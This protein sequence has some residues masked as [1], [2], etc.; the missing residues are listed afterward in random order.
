MGFQAAVA[1]WFA[2]HLLADEPIGSLFGLEPN[3]RIE[4]LQC[5]SDA[6]VD[7]VVVGLSGGGT[8][9]VQC[10]TRPSLSAAKDSALARTLQQL[11]DLYVQMNRSQG[12]R[13]S[14]TV[15]L[16]VAPDASHSLDQLETACRM[17][18]HGGSWPDVIA[19]VS[20][21]RGTA[22]ARFESLVRSAWTASTGPPITDDDLMAL[23]RMFRVRRF[24]ADATQT[25]WREAAHLLGRRV[26]G[27]EQAGA[28][29]M[30]ALLGLSRILIQTG[31]PANRAGLLRT[32]RAQGHIDVSAPGYEQDIAALLKHSNE[33]RQRLSKHM[34][35]PLGNGVLIQR[36]CL[37]PLFAAV[38]DGSL[39]VTGEPGAGKTGVLLALAERLE[40]GPGPLLFLSVERFAGIRLAS[41]LRAEL[42]VSQDP[43]DVLAAWPGTE[44]GVLLIDALDASRGGSSESIVSGFIADAVAKVGVRWSIVASIRSFDLR[45]GQRFREIMRG[46]PP[47]SNFVEDNMNNVRH[48]RVPRLSPAELV[49]VARKSP[50]VETLLQDAPKSVADL[51]RN[52]FNLSLAA[53]LLSSGHNV[54]SI[55]NVK[56]Q[57][58]LIQ[59]YETLRIPLQSE[60]AVQ[61]TVAAM[62]RRRQVAVRFVDIESDAVESV[63]R[64]GVLIKAG[65]LVTFAHHV[66]FDHIAARFYLSWDN[67][68][69]LQKQLSGDNTIGLLL[70]PA[71]RFVLEHTWQDDSAGRPA[72]WHLLVN[73]IAVPRP[74]PVLVSIAIRTAAEHVD[75]ATDVDGLRALAEA[76][77]NADAVTQ[78]LAQ[79]ARFVGMALDEQRGLSAGSALAWALVA[80][81]AAG[82]DDAKRVDAARVLLMYL[83][84]K[85]DFGNDDVA[86]SF[87]RAARR[88]LQRAWTL[89]DSRSATNAIRFVT[90][91]YGADPAASRALLEEIIGARF[92][93]HAWEEAPW[94]AEGVNT[95]LPH[96]PEFVVKIYEVLFTRKV[97]DESKT[98]LGGTA[99]RI[100][101]LTSTRRQDYE[102]AR[103]QLGRALKS[104]LDANIVAGTTAVVHAVRGMAA[105][106]HAQ[107]DDQKPIVV[108]FAGGSMHVIDDII[109]LSDWRER[110]SRDEEPLASFVTF[111]R[112]CSPEAFRGV[113]TTLFTLPTNAAVW[114]RVLGIAAERPGV[115]DA[116]LWPVA[117]VP[118]M[119]ALSGLTRDAV[120]FIA[121]A[122][123][124]QSLANRSAFEAATLTKDQFQVGGAAD[125]WQSVLDR[126][127]S[128]VPEDQLATPAMRALRKERETSAALA[129]NEPHIR[130]TGGWLPNDEIVDR[131]LGMS[132]SE[133]ER[134]PNREIRS[135]SRKVEQRVKSGGQSS[136]VATLT[137][138][139]QDVVELVGA[140]DDG[141]EGHPQQMLVHASWGAVCNGI[142][143]LAK[144]AAYEPGQW[145]MP[146][147]DALLALIDRLV[148]S[149]YPERSA[150]KSRHIGWGNW[151]VR[152]YAASS[153][154]ALAPRFAPAR[155]SIID[156]I[157]VC[158]RDETPTVRL[159]VAQALHSLWGV[160]SEQTMSMMQAIASQESHDG[161][162]H[163]FL[164]GPMQQLS[165]KDPKRCTELLSLVLDRQWSAESDGEDT[166]EHVEAPGAAARLA[167]VL[168]VVHSQAGAWAWI[169]TWTQRLP[170]STTYLIPIL[171]DLR[172][173]FFF[174]YREAPTPQHVDMAGRARHLLNTLVR[175]A[176]GAIA[177]SRPLLLGT[178]HKGTL[179]EDRPLCTAGVTIIDEVC[180]QLYFGSGAYQSESEP[181]ATAGLPSRDAKRRFLDDHAKVLEAIATHAPAPTVHHF[182]DLLA[183]LAEGNPVAVFDLAVKVLLGAGAEDGFQYESLGVRGLVGLLQLY[184]ADHRGIFEDPVRRKQLVEVLELFASVGW[185][186]ALRLLF[187]LPDLL[188]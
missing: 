184:L 139:W 145:G 147:L 61:A 37:E 100:L 161:V 177:A 44:R 82:G 143:I 107:K 169:E 153:L 136:D 73:L 124:T 91:S 95:I 18:D 133:R 14:R 155:P 65:D 162:L 86:A 58:E 175:A 178:T 38:A 43:I 41:E 181:K 164:A 12:A 176:E 16:A 10:K 46:T 148:E 51:L 141:E 166:A 49:E 71:L 172:E 92:N 52:I 150:S 165:R 120:I 142:E 187:E 20:G 68:A 104:V 72:T 35:L 13:T 140:L 59:Q 22:L 74:D 8:I 149:E 167:T 158:L 83:A 55:R 77:P 45:N 15:V 118:Q 47:Y 154:V 75:R 57:S 93:K 138:L 26:F 115:G 9:Y 53:D 174:A 157:E 106:N 33:E 27:G 129:G 168:F 125:E 185:P 30:A 81:S 103:W 127:L 62:V 40:T 69:V 80:D 21:E 144:S 123:G 94:L 98:S 105:K 146:S 117:T 79:L 66:L 7:D 108:P 76:S 89:K 99:S 131:L 152:V 90:R 64:T 2:V 134:S 5:E 163:F 17:F 186:D 4:N 50:E 78:L 97:T 128:S 170:R 3:R 116:L 119:L 87:G 60:R 135:A 171:Q 183:Y 54:H 112:T 11:V 160:A 122:Y 70:G 23:A 88:L 132:D 1:T 130:V 56:T 32:L 151:D 182:I 101:P 85:V 24:P 34:R 102:H 180:T 42:R 156:K 67:T 48:F 28:P 31:A 121:A 113:V 39:L 63:L 29:P 126:L 188:R 36:D 114:A 110:S 179:A 84:D 19:Q 111:L 109:S 6:P 137:A 96:D 159:Q 173:V 25:G